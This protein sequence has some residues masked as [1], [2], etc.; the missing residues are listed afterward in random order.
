MT[1]GS[2]AGETP[3]RSG[4]QLGRWP[5]LWTVHC[6]EPLHKKKSVYCA[7]NYR[8][9]HLTAQL[10]KTMESL[11]GALFLPFLLVN[12][13]FAPNQFAY[14]PQRGARDALAHMVLTWL[15]LLAAGRKIAVYCSEVSRAFD[16][17]SAARSRAKL[18]AK[19]PS[20]DDRR[21]GLFAP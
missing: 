9:V 21:L 11:P 5:D 19:N 4:L 2:A 15:P 12:A 18:Q 6:I 20:E 7:A 14:T 17:V 10:S 13:V 16:R 3:R 8:G 1:V